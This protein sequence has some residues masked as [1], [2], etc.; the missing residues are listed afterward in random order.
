M[1]PSQPRSS[2]Y[3]AG[4]FKARNYGAANFGAINLPAQ[5]MGMNAALFGA[6]G[7]MG[8]GEITKIEKIFNCVIYE[9]FITEFQ[10]MLKKYPHLQIDDIVKHLFHGSRETDP[11]LIY[12]TE[13]GLDFRFSNSGMYGRGIYFADN[14]QYSSNYAHPLRSKRG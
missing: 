9:K 14:S 10:R 4:M 13:T 8:R 11:A 1:A 12:G 3:P 7:G 2:K 5:A 6:G